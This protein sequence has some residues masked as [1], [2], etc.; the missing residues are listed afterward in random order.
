MLNPITTLINAV[1]GGDDRKVLAGRAPREAPAGAGRP[2]RFL[3][4]RDERRRPD[5]RVS[6]RLV[7]PLTRRRDPAMFN[8]TH[9]SRRRQH[10]V[11]DGMVTVA[12]APLTGRGQEAKVD[13]PLPRAGGDPSDR[14][15]PLS[16]AG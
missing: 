16:D 11:V 2:Q 3:T 13:R 10:T 4:V 8:H 6:P 5:G 14:L 12:P 1:T 7:R 15:E 9:R